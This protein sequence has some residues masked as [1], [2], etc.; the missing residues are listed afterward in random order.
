M[1]ASDLINEI[2]RLTYDDPLRVLVVAH[3]GAGTQ[4]ACDQLTA[5]GL[6]T[7]HEAFTK[8]SP[9]DAVHLMTF[10]EW[11]PDWWDWDARLWLVREP[12]RVVYSMQTLYRRRPNVARE[13][14]RTALG[15][16]EALD[17][18]LNLDPL[19]AALRSVVT[20]HLRCEAW[21]P[22]LLPRYRVEDIQPREPVPTDSNTHKPEDP[23]WWRLA[24]RD[25]EFAEMLMEQT[26]RYGYA[27]DESRLELR[28]HDK[29]VTHLENP[30]RTLVRETVEDSK[31]VL[32]GLELDD[33]R[34]SKQ[35][36]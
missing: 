20:M 2:E 17:D 3:P 18:V 16:P 19:R 24:E 7:A 25:L 11:A 31:A 12:I 21:G 14:A 32:A 29:F 6:P 33:R 15:D 35:D 27:I 10:K 30:F 13:V 4:W 26:A 23:D 36:D 28:D 22:K 8:K 9:P 34:G 5:A 1:S